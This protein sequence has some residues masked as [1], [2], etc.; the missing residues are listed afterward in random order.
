MK[1]YEYIKTIIYNNRMINIG[2]D[3]YGQTYFIEY[4][5]DGK[6]EE[7]CIGSYISDYEDYIEWRFGEP[8]TNC[9]I[10][11]SVVTSSYEC[12]TQKN[13]AFCSKCRKAHTDI[14]YEAWQERNKE[15][16]K[17]LEEQ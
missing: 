6:L 1:Q 12:C 4:I 5:E 16:E 7:E 14:D 8:E 9:P 10:Y 11:D 2:H 17:W 15:L 3:D 13:R